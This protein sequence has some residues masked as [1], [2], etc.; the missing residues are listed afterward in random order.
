MSLLDALKIVFWPPY[1][2]GGGNTV[3]LVSEG[4]N[5]QFEMEVDEQGY[6]SLELTVA[7]PSGHRR[8]LTC[9]RTFLR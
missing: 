8:V 9:S 4:A 1:W 3:E 5:Y 6:E 7:S 2:F